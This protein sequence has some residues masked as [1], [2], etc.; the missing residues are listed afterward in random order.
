MAKKEKQKKSRVLN[1]D[2]MR[3]AG[4]VEFNMDDVRQIQQEQASANAKAYEYMVEAMAVSANFMDTT[5]DDE[6]VQLDDV[7]PTSL[8]ETQRMDALLDQSEQAVVDPSDEEYNKMIT[9]L[10]G[11]VGWS[12]KKHFNFS[13]GIILG[14][15]ITVF[16][17]I[18]VAGEASSGK[19]K[20]KADMV[21]IDKWDAKTDTITLEAAMDS[22]KNGVKVDRPIYYKARK[23]QYANERI[24]A[25]QN[26]LATNQAH[27]DTATT[28]DNRSYYKEK[29]KA[30]QEKLKREQDRQKEISKWS[31]KDAK[32]DAYKDAKAF[33]RA[34]STWS[35]I[36]WIFALVF[37][38]LIPL[39]IFANYS[40]GYMLTKYRE[41]SELLNKIKQ[42][43][44]SAFF[45]LLG[46]SLAMKF[47]PETIVTTYYSN[48]S[49]STRRESNP[50]DMFIAMVKIAL[51]IAA[52]VVLAVVSTGIMIYSTIVG[53]KRN[54][55]WKAIY[56][57]AKE[58]GK[59][60]A[61]LAGKALDKGAE[62]VDKA[63]KAQKEKKEKP[64]KKAPQEQKDKHEL[65]D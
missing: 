34:A 4:L 55:D 9:A 51:I 64:E 59:D 48:G 58:T 23:L 7:Y 20:A 49:T 10:R 42:F 47:L 18:Y 41:E 60:A 32:K 3:R 45:G 50:A 40:Y 54:H 13:W 29:V 53:L 43:G 19:A 56:E 2:Q 62:L 12:F 30:F 46:A 22:L 24:E 16:A 27:L 1:N 33:Y 36:A 65:K 6:G 61:N 14:T 17:V 28:R 39:Y 26:D 25:Y 11:I 8:D 52:F 63:Q 5:I 44:Y 15:L 37:I 21:Y 35:L 57:Q 38:L 31:L